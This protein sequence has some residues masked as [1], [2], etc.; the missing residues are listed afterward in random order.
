VATGYVE[1]RQQAKIG[2][3]ATGRVQ[4]LYVEEGTFV[5][6]GFVLAILEHADL[7]AALAAAKATLR[8]TQA[9]A[10]EHEVEV[11][12]TK[13]RFEREERLNKAAASTPTT[14]DDAKFAYDSA[15]ARRESLAAAVELA[16]ARVQEAEQMTENMRIRA[17][18]DGTIISK[19]AELG[20]SILP[21][22]MG[23][24]SGRGS[25]ATIA[26][27]AHLEVECDVKEDYIGRVAFDQE[28]EVAVDAVPGR[29]YT[30]KVRKVI[31]MGDRARATIKVKVEI[32]DADEQLFP[33]MSATVYFLPDEEAAVEVP[34]RRVYCPE[35]AL[36]ENAEGEHVWTVDAEGRLRKVAVKVGTRDA[37]RAEILEGLS[38]GERVVLRP[39]PELHAEQLVKAVD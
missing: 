27:L 2:A 37:G 32:T 23:E 39:A 4:D 33:E 3:R 16:Q 6:E 20:E 11:A 15:I 22:G 24:A 28:C 38:G 5:K 18:F 12:R 9:Q 29:K 7:E 30:G 13:K 36:V 31:P 17:P 19:D 10:A 26:D 1:S 25:V 34:E 8:Q 21:G 14:Y 35:D